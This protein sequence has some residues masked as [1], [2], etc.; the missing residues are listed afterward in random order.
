M[1]THF[2][3]RFRVIFFS[4]QLSISPTSGKYLPIA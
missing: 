2:D 1:M 4:N 3:V